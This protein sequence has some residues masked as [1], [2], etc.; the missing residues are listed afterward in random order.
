MLSSSIHLIFAFLT[1]FFIK[2][3]LFDQITEKRV[4]YS[5]SSKVHETAEVPLS[6]SLQL[7]FIAQKLL[8]SFLVP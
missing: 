1:L 4:A 5:K 2:I 7:K 3:F 8:R 6:K